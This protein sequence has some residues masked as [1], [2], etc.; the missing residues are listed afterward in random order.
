MV[1]VPSYLWQSIVVTLLCCLPA[2]IVAIVYAS[3]VD[4][5]LSGGDVAGAQAASGS[6]KTWCWVSLGLG[7]LF[8]LIFVGGGA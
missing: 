8:G 4:S 1:E 7:L 6:A 5:L 3:K 2:G